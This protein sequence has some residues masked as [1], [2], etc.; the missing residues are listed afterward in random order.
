MHCLLWIQSYRHAIA[1]HFLCPDTKPRVG[2]LYE[3]L[4]CVAVNVT[5]YVLV[6]FHIERVRTAQQVKGPRLKSLTR[7]NFF[8][9]AA[10]ANS[11]AEGK[12]S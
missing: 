5:T 12:F 4:I 7:D 1:L 3:C 2:C 9:R 10:I 11:P 6:T 8:R